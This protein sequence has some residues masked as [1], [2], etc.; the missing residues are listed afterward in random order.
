MADLPT[1]D[2]SEPYV[3]V[4]LADI[5]LKLMDV[6]RKVTPLPADVADQELRLRLLETRMARFFGGTIVAG[7]VAGA[8]VS[9]LLRS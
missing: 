9:F 5:Y 7:A 3:R 8:L 2:H 1:T 6:E 4:T